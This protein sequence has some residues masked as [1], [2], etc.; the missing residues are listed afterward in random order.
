MA[1]EDDIRW[2][3]NEVARY[4]RRPPWYNESD[5]FDP[6]DPVFQTDTVVYLAYRGAKRR[7]FG[8]ARFVGQANLRQKVQD[9][10]NATPDHKSAVVT[11]VSELI[12]PELR[13]EVT[14]WADK[15]GKKK[16]PRNTSTSPPPS[17]DVATT[18]T[19]TTKSPRT[20]TETSP[21]ITL[22]IPPRHRAH[23]PMPANQEARQDSPPHSFSTTSLSKAEIILPD[24]LFHNL[25]KSYS[26]QQ[27]AY[28]AHIGLS[29]ENT[30]ICLLTLSIS[31]DHIVPT[32]ETLSGLQLQTDNKERYR[33]YPY[34]QLKLR[35]NSIMGCKIDPIS[36]FFGE[37]LTEAI[38]A[39]LTFNMDRINKSDVTQAVSIQVSDDTNDP[40]VLL[41]HIGPCPCVN[42]W[43][44]LCPPNI[45]PEV[46][47]SRNVPLADVA[48]P[49]TLH[50]LD[51][52]ISFDDAQPTPRW[53]V[54]K[55]QQI[56][57]RC[58]FIRVYTNT[59][60]HLAQASCEICDGQCI[61]PEGKELFLGGE[62]GYVKAQE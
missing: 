10:D 56:Y 17:E 35:L 26:A 1:T 45:T 59:N 24:R 37:L 12:T 30:D 52:E 38:Q 3:I 4:G 25:F 44:T 62:G 46:S 21:T 15:P 39:S 61:V 2:L 34:N 58:C 16:R 11:K 23:V 20:T 22:P 14:S 43:N 60:K 42:I 57:W 50:E 32:I 5:P 49:F 13:K 41:I 51:P 29:Y 7:A 33:Y 31:N 48:M 53:I 19:S 27:D 55:N 9:L 36:Q 28:V 18:A 8:T 40:G 54:G 47:R 6:V